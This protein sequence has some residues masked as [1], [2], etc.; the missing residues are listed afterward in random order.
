M[1]PRADDFSLGVSGTSCI[2]VSSYSDVCLVGVFD[3]FAAAMFNASI[4]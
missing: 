2:D 4:V 3:N 1:S